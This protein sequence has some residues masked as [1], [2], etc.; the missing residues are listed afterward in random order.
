M[1]PVGL[2]HWEIC[3]SK[4]VCAS[5]QLIAAYHVLHRLRVPR[6]PPRAL[7]NLTEIIRDLRFKI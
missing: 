3:G 5:P 2:S 4:A 1:T 7:S 6:H